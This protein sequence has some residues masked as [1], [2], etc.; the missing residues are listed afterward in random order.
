MTDTAKTSM[1]MK[2]GDRVTVLL[3]PSDPTLTMVLFDGVAVGCLVRLC[4]DIDGN[5]PQACMLHAI[6]DPQ[7]QAFYEHMR[8][9][10]FKVVLSTAAAVARG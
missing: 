6:E 4:V 8:E 9:I 10:G 7:Y 1:V 5:R 2:L 3:V